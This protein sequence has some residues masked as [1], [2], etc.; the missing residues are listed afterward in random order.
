MSQIIHYN[1]LTRCFIKAL[2]DQKTQQALSEELGYVFNVVA[3]WETNKRQFYWDEFIKLAQYQNLKINLF[4]QETTQFQY[5]DKLS[6]FEVVEVFLKSSETLLLKHFSKQKLY[7]LASGKSKLLFEDFL[8][9]LELV[10]NRSYRF[11]KF[12]LNEK[13]H[14]KLLPFYSHIDLASDVF[15]EDPLC[16]LLC[17]VLNFKIYKDIFN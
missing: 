14:S 12:C 6:S 13:H 8:K 7:R 15:A 2:R 9:M 11:L 16:S 10:Y 3:R 17:K 5:S 1:K 4:L